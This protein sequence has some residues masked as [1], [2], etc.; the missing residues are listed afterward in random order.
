MDV[1][2]FVGD[3][4]ALIR[5]NRS[6]GIIGGMEGSCLLSARFLSA[7][8]LSA[9]FFCQPNMYQRSEA[10]KLRTHTWRLRRVE[11]EAFDSS[12]VGDF[13]SIRCFWTSIRRYVLDP[14]VYP[15][16]FG[17]RKEIRPLPLSQISIVICCTLIG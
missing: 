16:R 14:R 17:F 3:S 2:L 12:K 9:K 6:Q 7:E 15:I 11:S 10:H 13:T 4:I 5:L 8:F 1:V